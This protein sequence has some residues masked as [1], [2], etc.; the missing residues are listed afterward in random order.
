[1][2]HLTAAICRAPAPTSASP[3]SIIDCAK[4]GGK[5]GGNLGPS[6]SDYT[7][8]RTLTIKNCGLTGGLPARFTQKNVLMSLASL[9]LS[10][11]SLS[12]SLPQTLG[13]GGSMDSL[14][15]MDLSNNAFTVSS[16]PARPPF[17]P[18]KPRVCLLTRPLACLPSLATTLPAARPHIILPRS[19]CPTNL[20]CRAP[21]LPS[22]PPEATL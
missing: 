3:R 10:G 8:L 19:F 7:S 20:Y 2:G 6:L 18:L 5:L 12:G 11:N 16:V 17:L 21:C 9:D 22:G 13:Q 14:A 4:W 1:M 15:S